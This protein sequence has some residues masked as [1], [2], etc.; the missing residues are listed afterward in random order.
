M[1]TDVADFVGFSA[2]AIN[3]HKPV[4]GDVI[5]LPGVV[6]NVGGAYSPDTFIFTCP[7]TAYYYI[8][9]SLYIYLNDPNYERCHVAI[10]MDEE[11]VVEV[12]YCDKNNTCQEFHTCYIRVNHV[13]KD[14]IV[15]VVVI[16]Y[17]LMLN[18]IRQGQQTADVGYIYYYSMLSQ[19]VVLECQQSSLI[20][21]QSTGDDCYVTASSSERES[22]FGGFM[23]ERL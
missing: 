20:W 4:D 13:G 17:K 23:L 14:V 18:C 21:L 5:E 10:I 2:Y 8:Y 19:S 6:T 12:R 16:F 1:S 3:S 15:D 22:V 11:V 9:F 7:T